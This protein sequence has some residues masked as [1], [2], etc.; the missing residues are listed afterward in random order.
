MILI[1]V[2]YLLCI[3]KATQQIEICGQNV[4]VKKKIEKNIIFLFFKKKKK[5]RLHKFIHFLNAIFDYFSYKWAN[6]VL[7]VLKEIMFMEVVMKT[8]SKTRKK[9]IWKKIRKT[10]AKQLYYFEIH[11]SVVLGK[12][13]R[14]MNA[15]VFVYDTSQ[16]FAKSGKVWFFIKFYFIFVNPTHKI[17]L[18]QKTKKKKKT[19]TSS[20]YMKISITK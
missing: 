10:N 16:P 2:L 18:Q 12:R 14:D 20:K 11:L 6:I 17:S 7:N 4:Q 15:I 13:Y 3:L 9:K 8:N 5:K 19:I 1:F